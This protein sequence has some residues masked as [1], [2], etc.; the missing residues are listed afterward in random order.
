MKPPRNRNRDL[1]DHQ[2][3]LL[4]NLD[5]QGM[6]TCS[7]NKERYAEVILSTEYYQKIIMEYLDGAST[8]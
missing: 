3:D 5:L 4:N 1:L 6:E 2:I 8:S 7:Q